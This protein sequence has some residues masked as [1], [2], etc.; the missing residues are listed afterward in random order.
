MRTTVI[1]LLAAS[2]A[3]AKV[4]DKSVD[5]GGV[6]VHCKVIL[7]KDYDAGKAY[8]AVL[9]FPPGSQAMDMVLVT[10]QRNWAAEAEKR[11]YIVI[12]PAAPGGELFFEHGAR[13]FPQ[14]IEQMLKDCARDTEAVF[15]Q[16]R[17][18]L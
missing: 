8:P 13:I 6:P 16:V 15:T 5:I 17:S 10:V 3:L 18:R 2:C 11:G 9:A 7:P 12:V 1:F 14:F 4:Y